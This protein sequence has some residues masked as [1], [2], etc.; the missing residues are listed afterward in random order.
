MSSV[1]CLDRWTPPGLHMFYIIG[2]LVK[3]G[4]PV[5]FVF[6]GFEERIGVGRIGG[7]YGLG[8]HYPDRYTFLAPGIDITGIFKRHLGI[9]GVQGP[10]MF[11]V[12]SSM[13]PDKYF[14]QRK[15]SVHGLIF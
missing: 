15:F 13:R 1:S 12:E 8:R 11:V 9:G 4:M 10:H 5:N 2:D 3:G 7:C 14:P 6:G